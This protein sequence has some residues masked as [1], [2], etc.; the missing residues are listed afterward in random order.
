MREQVQ[1]VEVEA[2]RAFDLPDHLAAKAD[3]ALIAGDADHFEAIRET[4]EQTIAQLSGRLD[5]FL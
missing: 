2:A 4:L 5:A 3:P 1:G